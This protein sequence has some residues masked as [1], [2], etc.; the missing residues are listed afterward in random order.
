MIIQSKMH[1]LLAGAMVCA[2]GVLTVQAQSTFVT[3]SVDMGTNILNGTFNP[4]SDV[5]NVR[6]TFNNWDNAQTPMI[7]AGT[8]TIYTNTVQDTFDAG[9]APLRYVFNI[10]GS[11]YESPA[12][13]NNRAAVLPTASGAS[14]VLP[15]P[16]YG[17]SGAQVT[18]MVTFQVDVSQQINVGIFTQGIS[19][20]EIRG[21]FNSWTGGASELTNNPNILVTNQFGLVTSNVWQ[22][23][24]PVAA[25][26][27]SA[28]DFKY[29]IQPGT[30]WDGP[31]AI[32]SDSG[33]NRFWTSNPGADLVLP[34]VDFSDSPFAPLCA[35]VYTVDMSGPAGLDTGY[36][37]TTV[38]LDGSFNGWAQDVPMTNNPGAANSNLFSTT[39]V[40]G[41]GSSIQYQYRY[42]SSGSTVYDHLNGA[43]GG[44]GNRVVNIPTLANYAIPNVFFNDASFNDYLQGNESVTFTIDMTGAVGT[45]TTVW[46]PGAAVFVNGPWPNWLGWDPIS[47]AGQQLAEVGSTAIYTGTFSIP[48]G[49]VTSLTY[50]FSLGGGDN[51]AGQDNN[52]A[53]VIRSTATGA[54]SFAQ[55]KF[56]NQ[57]VEP[58]FGQLMVGSASAGNV[59]LSWLGRPGCE[60]QIRSGSLNSGSWMSLPL[61]DGTNWTAGTYS[62]NGLVS[63]T[64]WP[65]SSGNLF[66]RLIKQ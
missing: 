24:F 62:T 18:N 51:E 16:F 47:L 12:S 57:Y 34:R 27:W 55:D 43:T 26:P 4:G 42:N 61:T 6:G 10:N 60:V 33:G 56:G 64:N 53:R 17:D 29:V 65:A 44:Q 23:A 54:Y 22:G 48:K 21:N 8:S 59:P 49:I 14:V 45:D 13:F 15:T 25:S 36:D 19:S 9:V 3:I 32:N 37:P 40:I 7:Q 5:V 1:A 41:Q 63:S 39:V 50:K 35:T 38:R 46:T 52:H 58:S 28:Q 11:A 31:S 66:F 20:V 30:V 2:A